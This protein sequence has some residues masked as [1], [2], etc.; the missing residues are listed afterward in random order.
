MMFPMSRLHLI[1]YIAF[2]SVL[3]SMAQTGRLFNGDQLLS[4]SFVHHVYQDKMGFVWVS[5]DNGL[6][7]YDG[8]SFL[9]FTESDGLT[10][11]SVICAGETSEGNLIVGTSTGAFVKINGHFHPV[12]LENNGDT[13]RAYVTS[14]A[15]TLRGGLIL[16]SSGGGLYMMTGSTTAMPLGGGGF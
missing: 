4:S 9:T 11:P 6:N 3:T 8:Y 1:I 5:T 12:T 7:R 13:L 2:L 16:G 14:F 10:D 15:R